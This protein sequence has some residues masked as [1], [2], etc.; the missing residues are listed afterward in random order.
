MAFTD[1]DA[2][3]PVGSEKGKLLDDYIRE[4]KA[5]VET[6]LQ[7]I[8][9]YPNL[10]V[11]ITQTWTTAG[12]PNINLVAGMF[13]Y[14]TTLGALEHWTG[15]AWVSMGTAPGHTHA[16][17]EVTSAVANATLATTATTANNIPTSDVGGNIWIA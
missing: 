8:S 4:L 16:G 11:L 10:T 5:Q 14:N 1:I 17:A 15:S 13:G 7:Q 9:G 2:T 3:R 12:R 6:N